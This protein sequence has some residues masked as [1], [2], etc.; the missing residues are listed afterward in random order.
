M[1]PLKDDNNT[2][3]FYNEKWDINN[4]KTTFEKY[5]LNKWIELKK[6]LKKK[7]LSKLG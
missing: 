2:N 1:Y 5:Y 7:E 4:E 3:V 6:Y